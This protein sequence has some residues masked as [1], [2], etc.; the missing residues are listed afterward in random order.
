MTP[1]PQP[2]YFLISKDE[3]NF[4]RTSMFSDRGE[5]RKI[6]QIVLTRPHT[7]HQ[8]ERD[9]VLDELDVELESVKSRIE[10]SA[11]GQPLSE[12]SRGEIIGLLYAREKMKYFRS[13]KGGEG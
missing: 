4:M 2:E 6:M 8:S 9:K 5:C 1:P 13:N 11:M 3:I 12:R 10:S 7:P